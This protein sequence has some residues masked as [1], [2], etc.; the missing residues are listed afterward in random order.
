MRFKGQKSFLFS[1]ILL[2]V[3]LTSCA[4]SFRK[5]SPRVFLRQWAYS[6]DGK[7]FTDLPPKPLSDLENYI[8]GGKGY[9]TLRT[10]FE[11]PWKL[12]S[13]DVGL[14]LGK[15]LIA[16]NI[17]LNGKEI[18]GVGSFPPHVRSAG[19]AYTN[20]RLNPQFLNLTGSNSL[21]IVMWVDGKGGIS[22][23]P[24]ISTFEDTSRFTNRMS[25]FYSKLN[26][27]FAWSMVLTA[28]IY[29]MFYAQ[30][31]NE[32]HYRDYALMNL[33]TAVFLIPFWSSEIPNFLL[34]I[35]FLWWNTFFIGA[36]A[37]VVTHFAA[38]FICSFLSV[39]LSLKTN[40]IRWIIL[41]AGVFY[42]VHIPDM[43]FFYKFLGLTV[44]LIGLQLSVA[45]WV[46][47]K[48][49]KKGNTKK[50]ITLLW[51]F[52]PVFLT[53]AVDFVL[54]FILKLS[55]VPLMTISGWQMTSITFI[56]IVTNQYSHIRKSFEYLNENLEKEVKERT[57]E[58]TKAN[59]ELER[60]QYEADRD[61]QLAVH[62]Q[63]SFYPKKPVFSGWDV[64]VS[65]NPLSG[66]SGDMYDFFVM[67]GKLRG[68]GL[69]DVS[70]HGISSGLVTMLAKNSIFHAFKTS[71]PLKL[72]EAMEYINEQVIAVKGEIENYLTGI[73]FR[74]DPENP[75]NLEFV[76]AGGPH[77]VFKAK[78]KKKESV[79]LLPDDKKPHYGM[80]GVK[81]LD[82]KFQVIKKKVKPG[83]V[84]VLYTDGISETENKD[85]EPFGKERIM[86]V[87]NN[88]DG[89][90]QEITDAIMKD[91]REFT[92]FEKLDDDITVLVMKRVK[93]EEP[94]EI[95][96]L[97][98][99]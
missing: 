92:G 7:N 2:S 45:I 17:Y 89:T 38:S 72:D 88:V 33:G 56:A 74:I 90:A 75:E 29:L 34:S 24:F 67:E 99:L 79:L 76:N 44:V 30:Q 53:L 93:E 39:K 52:S 84:L 64:G 58:L 87:L 63:Q 78:G 41:G 4:N 35:P 23:K 94:E 37:F 9:I 96:E 68:F 19:P 51:G 11:L 1:L 69:F 98:S 20:I 50:I 47:I 18:S 8:P 31:R 86:Q 61:M 66:V 48:E 12:A 62:V 27:V 36:A 13:G 40:I 6:V 26:M 28:I 3:L 65:F 81:G 70:G 97:E 21:E 71:L 60:A 95:L 22:D 82:V 16:A 77:P 85:G 43:V 14:A 25:F 46:I 42:S 10:D 80:I 55:M 73:L 49:W 59:E 91:L 57:S 15:I 54:K 5:E 32:K 83:D